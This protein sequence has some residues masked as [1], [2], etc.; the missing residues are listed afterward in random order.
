MKEHKCCYL[1]CSRP[2]YLH[3]G[4][5]GGDSHW[6]CSYHL[7]HWHANRARFDAQGLPCAMEKLGEPVCGEC[8][9]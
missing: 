3:I 5:N 8:R 4:F 2:S 9:G 6:I 1:D 7:D